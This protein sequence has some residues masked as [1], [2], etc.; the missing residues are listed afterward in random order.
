MTKTFDYWWKLYL[1]IRRP[2]VSDKNTLEN[3]SDK[4]G[5]RHHMVHFR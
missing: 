2:V 3:L 1:I 4:I 5:L